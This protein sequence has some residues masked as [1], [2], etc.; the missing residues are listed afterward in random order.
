MHPPYDPRSELPATDPGVAVPPPLPPRRRWRFLQPILFLATCITLTLMGALMWN[1]E[2][3]EALRAA[4]GDRGA[5][6]LA[7]ARHGMAYA[8]CVLAILGS[9]EMGHYFACRYYG[10]PATLPFFLPAPFLI[11]TLGAVIRIR[12]PIPHRRALF[13]IAAAGPIA[14]FLVAI[15]VTADR[16]REHGCFAT[17][18]AAVRAGPL[19]MKGRARARKGRRKSLPFQSVGWR[20]LRALRATQR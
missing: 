14:G 1:P 2:T 12:G 17:S 5:L 9:H 16:S 3:E 13:D 20:P 8:I 15:P 18:R 6:L 19:A 10:I 4:E 11:G 7:L